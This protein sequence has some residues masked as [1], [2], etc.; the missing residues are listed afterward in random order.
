[1]KKDLFVVIRWPD[2]Q[3]FIGKPNC[4]LINDDEGVEEFG[5]SAYFVRLDVYEEITQIPVL[6]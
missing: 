4:Y 6:L 2:S 5:S 1:M 3:E